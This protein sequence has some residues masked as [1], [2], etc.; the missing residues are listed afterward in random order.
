MEFK[1]VLTTC[2]YCAVGCNMLLQV[3]DG[4]IVG[5]LPAKTGPSNEGRLCIKGWTVHEFVQYQDRLTT[6]LWRKNGSLRTT[7]WD[8]ALDFSASEL[9][10]LM[11]AYGPDSVAFV[12]SARCTNEETY[13]FQK[14]ARAVFGHNHIDHCARL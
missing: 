14:F 1:T 12:G 10:R 7:S 9:N 6:P 3:L 11:E 8:Q 2:P 5:T 4:E 13:I